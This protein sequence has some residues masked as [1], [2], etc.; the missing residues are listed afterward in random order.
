MRHI[1]KAMSKKRGCTKYCADAKMRRG[2]KWVRPHESCPYHELD[3]F[4]TYEDYYEAT[5]TAEMFEEIK[6]QL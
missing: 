4:E 5:M 3:N 1:T 2:G 6:E